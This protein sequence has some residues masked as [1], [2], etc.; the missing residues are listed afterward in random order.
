MTITPEQRQQYLARQERK[1]K[2]AEDA[3]S[4]WR[5]CWHANNYNGDK[6]GRVHAGNELRQAMW[7]L[8]GLMSRWHEIN[9]PH[10]AWQPS[11]DEPIDMDHPI[12]EFCDRD[13]TKQVKHK[14]VIYLCE[15]CS[16]ALETGMD[17]VM[18]QALSDEEA[19]KLPYIG[20]FDL[21]QEKS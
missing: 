4:K 13:A 9:D 8:D 3:A 17:F 11:D 1:I 7:Q 10:S 14:G 20:P 19:Q 16:I 6:N 5:H 21:A 18:I 15:P 12:C 2:A